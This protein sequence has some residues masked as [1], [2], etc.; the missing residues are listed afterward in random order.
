MAFSASDFA[1]RICHRRN[2]RVVVVVVLLAN[3]LIT[4]RQAHGDMIPGAGLKDSALGA[5]L[6]SEQLVRDQYLSFLH[7]D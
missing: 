3:I 5:L 2:R 6:I 4:N 7:F 1:I